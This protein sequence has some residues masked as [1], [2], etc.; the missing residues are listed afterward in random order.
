MLRFA[1]L[2]SG[3]HGNA[4]VVSVN[5][6]H[7][8]VDCGFSIKETES[9]LQRLQ[10]EATQLDAIL[11]THEHGD[12][13]QGVDRIARKYQLPVW[14]TAGT[15]RKAR[16]NESL[17]IQEFNAHEEFIIQ[18]IVVE[19]FPVPHDAA[20]PAQFV[21]SDGQRRLGLL[22]DTGCSTPHIERTLQNCDALMLEYNHDSEMLANGPYHQRLKLR[23]GGQLGHLSNQQAD[24]LLQALISD[25]LQHLVAMHLSEKNNHPDLVRQSISACLGCAVDEV[26]ISDQENGVSWLTI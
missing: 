14:L 15:R 7:I 19:P 18:D 16:L 12:H 13:I 11:V 1:S 2:G 26:L 4:H 6:T 23:V 20:E 5:N 8:L 9:R 22:T 25:K 10:L 24:G 17:N 3:S 21:F